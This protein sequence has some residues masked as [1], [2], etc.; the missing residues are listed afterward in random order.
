MLPEIQLPWQ[1]HHSSVHILLPLL[2]PTMHT[3]HSQLVGNSQPLFQSLCGCWLF[4]QHPK[5]GDGRHEGMWPCA[6]RNLEPQSPSSPGPDLLLVTTG[7]RM[8]TKGFSS[9]NLPDLIHKRGE[10]LVALCCDW[11]LALSIPCPQGAGTRCHTSWAACEG[12]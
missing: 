11:H 10:E 3:E 5:S 6:G 7:I 12:C 8:G 4:W 2:S 1:W 9:G